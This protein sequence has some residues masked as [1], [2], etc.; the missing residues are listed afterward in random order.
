M[1]TTGKLHMTTAWMHV[2]ITWPH[3]TAVQKTAGAQLYTQ[4]LNCV[5]APAMR[6]KTKLKRT[7]F[8][9]VCMFVEI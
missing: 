1:K 7:T 9:A 4:P 8:K 5:L 3:S 6:N 2:M